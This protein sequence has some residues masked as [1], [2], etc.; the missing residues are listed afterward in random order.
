[1]MFC[2]SHYFVLCF[3]YRAKDDCDKENSVFLVGQRALY[4]GVLACLTL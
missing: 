1:M 4:K 2:I 3:G